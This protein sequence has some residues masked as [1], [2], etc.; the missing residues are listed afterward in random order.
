M[1]TS[2]SNLVTVSLSRRLWRR[3]TGSRTGCCCCCCCRRLSARDWNTGGHASVPI[4]LITHYAKQGFV[5]NRLKIK[6]MGQITELGLLW[7]L[8][9]SP[10]SAVS[11]SHLNA[12]SQKR[13]KIGRGDLEDKAHGK[14]TI[15]QDSLC[16]YVTDCLIPKIWALRL[17]CLPGF[18]WLWSFYYVF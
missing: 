3:L 12:E 16:Y 8:S 17:V 2:R 9:V 13:T 18:N 6:Q 14:T 7:P 15:T 4:A 11:Q 10:P 5:L 1:L